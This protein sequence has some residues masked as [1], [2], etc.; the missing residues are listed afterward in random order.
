M[1]RDA[2]VV[3]ERE[4]AQPA[5]ESL[6]A[7]VA[8]VAGVLHASHARLVELTAEALEGDLWC[9]AGVHSPAQWL[10]WQ[11]GVSPS[12]ARQIVRVARRVDELPAM[13]R[14]LDGGE[15]SLDQAAVVAARCPTGFDDDVVG[16]AVNATVPQLRRLLGRYQFADPVAASH[17]PSRDDSTDDDPKAD[18]PAPRPQPSAGPTPAERRELSFWY[19]DD[20]SFH[21]HLTLP[22]DEGAVVEA[23]LV[24]TRDE[25]FRRDHPDVEPGTERWRAAQRELSWAD[26]AVALAS[27]SLAAGEATYGGSVVD[28]YRAIVHLEADPT[29]PNG[30]PVAGLHLGAALPTSIRRYLLCDGDLLPVWQRKGTPI[31]HGRS[32]R[33]VP[34]KVRLLVE[35][36]DGGCR[37]PGCDRTRWLHV[38]H[39]IH[40]E[41]LG[42]TE[43]ENLICLC[44]RHHR[45]HHLG[46]LPITGTASELTICDERGRPMVPVGRPDP[47]PLPAD[48][49]AEAAARD[50]DPAVYRHPSGERVDPKWVDFAPNVI[51][52][53]ERE[54]VGAGVGNNSP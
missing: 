13:A 29:N 24:A 5:I 12:R 44:Q 1:K 45:L 40:W 36:R 46:K 35:H 10:A 43:P 49:T 50:I 21:Q 25:L 41:D 3:G 42:E 9:Q 34:P 38:H 47:V 27:D 54:P 28:R 26:A 15:L 11:V 4:G 51:A 6:E 52:P 7:R 30:A 48:L 18:D 20:G 22:A 37:V 53:P 17:D 2:T 31:A 32:Q 39:I 16:V 8:S 14:A 33:V 19:D 23:A